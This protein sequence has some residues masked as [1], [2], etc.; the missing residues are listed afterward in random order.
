MMPVRVVDYRLGCGTWSPIWVL[1]SQ[2]GLLRSPPS[3]LG[4]VSAPLERCARLCYARLSAAIL[5]RMLPVTQGLPART[6]ARNLGA[7]SCHEF[8]AAADD[9]Q[10]PGSAADVDVELRGSCFYQNKRCP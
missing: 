2:P 6:Q 8:L 10:P 3:A 5:L 9:R 4:P 1:I 7:L